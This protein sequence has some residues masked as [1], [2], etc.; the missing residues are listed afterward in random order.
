MVKMFFFYCDELVLTNICLLFDHARAAKQNWIKSVCLN[1]KICKCILTYIFTNNQDPKTIEMIRI[2]DLK[3]CS[4]HNR[5]TPK[6]FF[7]NCLENRIARIFNLFYWRKA[8]LFR[9]N[10]SLSITDCVSNAYIWNSSSSIM[11][12]PRHEPG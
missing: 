8:W 4:R 1:N 3:H 10:Q 9:N 11:S 6:I 12:A 2:T 7:R 5:T